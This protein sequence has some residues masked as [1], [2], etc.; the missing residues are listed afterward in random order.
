MSTAGALSRW[1]PLTTQHS[2]EWGLP[3]LALEINKQLLLSIKSH[4]TALAA[5]AVLLECALTRWRQRD[6]TLATLP[7][8][9]TRRG[10]RVFKRFAFW[11]SSSLLRCGL[12][13]ENFFKLCMLSVCCYITELSVHVDIW[14]R[15]NGWLAIRMCRAVNHILKLN[16]KHKHCIFI[17]FLFIYRRQYKHV[18]WLTAVWGYV[19]SVLVMKWW[20]V[21]YI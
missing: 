2:A 9:R 7:W 4:C 18:N 8:S 3:T 17:G 12:L 11:C 20:R 14:L 15:K 5:A 6:V 13:I 10:D 1:L 19:K 16:D 21:T